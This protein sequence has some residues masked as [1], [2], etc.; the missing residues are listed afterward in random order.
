MPNKPHTKPQRCE[1]F[2]RYGGAFTLG[3]VKWEQCKND[4]TVMLKLA[5]DNEPAKDFPACNECWQEALENK[6]TILKSSPI[7]QPQS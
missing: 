4:A 2:R 3:P 6:I 5:Q 1:G 7:C